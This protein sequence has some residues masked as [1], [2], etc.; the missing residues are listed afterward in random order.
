M[1][2][3]RDV[4]A[5]L[6]ALTRQ[7]GKKKPSKPLIYALAALAV[8]VTPFAAYYADTRLFPVIT[9]ANAVIMQNVAPGKTAATFVYTKRRNC[10]LLGINFVLDGETISPLRV[11]GPEVLTRRPV[12]RN[13]SSQF[14]VDASEAVFIAR[15][16]VT[17]EHEC[18]LLW[19]HFS[20][21]YGQ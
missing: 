12:G 4:E 20:K 9:D 7:A 19:H 3:Q 14:I 15:G 21:L 11:E 6:N 13:I 8:A 16:L 5:K 17:L 2:D 1:I 18:H 10:K